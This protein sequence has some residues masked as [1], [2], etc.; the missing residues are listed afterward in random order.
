MKKKVFPKKLFQQATSL[1]SKLKKFIVHQNRS[2]QQVWKRI[3][4]IYISE[5]SFTSLN[6][7]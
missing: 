5:P 3:L 6:K 7:M 2:Q 1:M 4:P